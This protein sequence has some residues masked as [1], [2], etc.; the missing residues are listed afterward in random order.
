MT[1]P[2]LSSTGSDISGSTAVLFDV[3]GAAA[4]PY[5]G[6]AGMAKSSG[7]QNSGGNVTAV[8]ISPS[9]A[10]GLVI[11]TLGVDSNTINDVSPGNFLSAVPAPVASPNPV[12]Q[13]NGWAL[14]YNSSSVT[15]TFVCSTQRRQPNDWSSI[16]APFK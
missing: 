4:S 16:S 6:T 5:D 11:S 3:S 12:D 13:N 1:G 9:T 15:G 10:N 8:T 2:A 14:W 7:V